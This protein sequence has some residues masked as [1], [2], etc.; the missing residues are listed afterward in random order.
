MVQRWDI[1][2]YEIKEINPRSSIQMEIGRGTK[3]VYDTF[4]NK[5]DQPA[6]I[7]VDGTREWYKDGLQYFPE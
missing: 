1:A 7:W 3:M 5:G 6:I 2:I 4:Q